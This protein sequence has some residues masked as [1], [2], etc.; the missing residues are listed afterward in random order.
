MRVALQVEVDQSQTVPVLQQLVQPHRV[1]SLPQSGTQLEPTSCSPQPH[2]GGGG[3]GATHFPLWQLVP[4]GQVPLLQAP[5]QPSGA[6]H[7]L[8]VQ[9]GWHTHLPDLQTWPAGQLP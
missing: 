7:G 4:A 6:P 2:L 5:P 9:L 8:P 3:N 1:L